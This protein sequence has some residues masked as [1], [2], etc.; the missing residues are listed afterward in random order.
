MVVAVCLALIA[1]TAAGAVVLELTEVVWLS[2]W[3]A[4]IAVGLT[5]WTTL[6]L[7]LLLRQR[8]ELQ[9]ARALVNIRPLTGKLPLD[10]GGWAAGP[11]LMDEIVRQLCRSRPNKVVECGSGWSTVLIAACLQELGAGRVVALEHDEKFALRTRNLLATFGCSARAEVR[12]A[13]LTSQTVEGDRRV[14]YDAG[15]VKSINGPIDILLVDGPPGNL[16]SYIRYPA[17]PLLDR[18]FAEECVI[19]LDD[20]YRDDEARIAHRW[21]EYL[22]VKPVLETRGNGFWLVEVKKGDASGMNLSH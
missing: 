18:E 3:V 5:L 11:V 13:P 2:L 20:G 16:D 12:M 19:F 9:Q 21:G 15:A 8:R 7:C 10:L 17:V 14:W 6:A 1:G 4:V 22:G